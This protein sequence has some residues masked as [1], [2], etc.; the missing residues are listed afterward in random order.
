MPLIA[1][2]VLA[3]PGVL[4]MIIHLLRKNNKGKD[5]DRDTDKDTAGSEDPGSNTS[6]KSTEI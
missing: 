3:V 4:I 2:L 5:T 1:F 6:N